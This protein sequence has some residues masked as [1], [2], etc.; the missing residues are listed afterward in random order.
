LGTHN[1]VIGIWRG[2]DDL[3]IDHAWPAD[4]TYGG[5]PLI[6]IKES[7]AEFYDT[8]RFNFH[9]RLGV[10][11]HKMSLSHLSGIIEELIKLSATDHPFL[12]R[13]KADILKLR[14]AVKATDA[15]ESPTPNGTKPTI[16]VT[17]T[18]DGRP[19]T[20]VTHNAPP[21]PRQTPPATPEASTPTPHPSPKVPKDTNAP[22]PPHATIATVDGTVKDSTDKKKR[23]RKRKPEFQLVPDTVKDSS[24]GSGRASRARKTVAVGAIPVNL[25]FLFS[26]CVGGR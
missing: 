20:P 18:P 2:I 12:F 5:L 21:P 16:P 9:P 11:F 23:T 26:Y 19:K 8:E 14:D 4:A 6:D 25:D 7:P 24:S 15:P 10:P 13:S 22:P 1:L 17:H 3:L